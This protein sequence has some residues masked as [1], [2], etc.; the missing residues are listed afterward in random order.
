MIPLVCILLGC[1]LLWAWLIGHWFARVVVF[2]L[3]AC[4]LF[5]VAAA[6][7]GLGI[8]GGHGAPPAA[9]LAALPAAA[10]AW[11]LAGI[12]QYVQHYRHRKFAR[13]SSAELAMYRPRSAVWF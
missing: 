13:M 3:F 1:G 8:Y 10:L 4:A 9:L 12:P 7:I 6:F 5:A 2:L 11:P